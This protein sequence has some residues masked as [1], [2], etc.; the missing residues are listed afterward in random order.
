MDLRFIMKIWYKAMLLDQGRFYVYLEI[1]LKQRS[2]T[3]L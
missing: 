2:F 3:G 1:E